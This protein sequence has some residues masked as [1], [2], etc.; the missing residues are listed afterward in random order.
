MSVVEQA[1]CFLSVETIKPQ[2]HR[3]G[4]AV[5]NAEQKG[6]VLVSSLH[7]CRRTGLSADSRR[8]ALG[9]CFCER[10]QHLGVT[11]CETFLKS[12]LPP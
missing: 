9:L 6:P 1:L 5:L 8:E 4:S 11:V 3:V 10:G 12:S 2:G 7:V